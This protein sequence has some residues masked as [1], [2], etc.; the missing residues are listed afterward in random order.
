MSYDLRRRIYEALS[1]D[2]V[3]TEMVG[4]RVMARTGLEETGHELEKPF[5]VYFFG[6]TSKIGPT[7][8]GAGG[9]WV[10]VWAHQARGDFFQVDQILDRC[11]EVLE[12]LPHE[13]PFYELRHLE[14]SQDLEDPAMETNCRF[15]RYQ[16]TLLA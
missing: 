12:A 15:D 3:L 1:G 4:D 9:Q 10:H 5:L 7:T 2:S 6:F 14:R 8:V 16:A 13:G 11:R